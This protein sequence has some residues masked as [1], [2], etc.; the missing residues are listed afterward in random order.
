MTPS[1]VSDTSQQ[2]GDLF[3]TTEP[4]VGTLMTGINML[5]NSINMQP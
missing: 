2:E 4:E 3:I 1:R 5:G